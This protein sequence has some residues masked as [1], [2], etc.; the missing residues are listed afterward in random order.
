MAQNEQDRPQERGEGSGASVVPESAEAISRPSGGAQVTCV[1]CPDL[2]TA[3]DAQKL[4]A[5]SDDK[6]YDLEVVK[7][8][9]GVRCVYLNDFRVAGEKPW[10]SDAIRRFKVRMT[11]I[12][13]AFRGTL[14][15]AAPDLARTVIALH[16]ELAQ[17]RAAA[18]AAVAV[19]TEKAAEI[20]GNR[21]WG[22]EIAK[23]IR[24]L[25][26]ED[27]IAEVA[28]LREIAA[29]EKELSAAYLRIRAK[30]GAWNTAPGGVDRF[31]V[32]E[33]ALDRLS[34][35]L[36]AANAREAGLREALQTM[37]AV[38]PKAMKAVMYN[39]RDGLLLA[40][41]IHKADDLARAA[42]AQPSTEGG[43]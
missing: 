41:E 27:A 28:K 20:A 35:E 34:A 11:D 31:E 36:A 10:G 22:A 7:W 23:T 32:T 18:L 40:D 4:L 24:E 15:N 26:T 5:E 25:A 12:M 42:L 9:G 17:A 39:G 8:E 13:G 2:I 19:A 33:A 3:E 16:A 38:A 43:E 6:V 1:E 21:A 29:S 37:R 14:Q 30:L